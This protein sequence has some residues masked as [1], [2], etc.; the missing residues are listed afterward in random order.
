MIKVE[1][2]SK[3]FGSVNAVNGVSFECHKGQ[4]FALLGSNGA[5]KTTTIRMISTII[6]PDCGRV[7]VN[8]YDTTKDQDEVRRSIGVLNSDVGLYGRLT[9]YE[10]VK[11]FAKLHGLHTKTIDRRIDELFTLMDMNEFRNRKVE[12]FSKGMKQK[13]NIIRAIIHDPSTILF[14]E[15]TS[16]L[17]VISA[18]NILDFIGECRNRGKC[19]LFSTHI[20]S[21][22]ERLCDRVAIINKGTIIA[23]G[24]TKEILEKTSQSTIED[25]YLKLVSDKPENTLHR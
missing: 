21:E 22:V 17:D 9:A 11:Y 25:A 23:Q 13:V 1:G 12:G 18:R 20:M 7:V 24:S 15:P 10:N 14:D 3:S 16:G 2:V 6:K 4:I 19:I 8:G 5:G